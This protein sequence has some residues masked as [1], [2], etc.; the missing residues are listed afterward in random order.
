[1]AKASGI[2]ESIKMSVTSCS[3]EMILPLHS[4]LMRPHLDYCVQFWAPQFKKDRD[5]LEGVQWRTTKMIKG[6]EHF[7]YE[8]KKTERGS[9][10]C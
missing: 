8:G 7:P 3:R 10:K 4:P 2:L 9:D 6:L 1:M 5:F